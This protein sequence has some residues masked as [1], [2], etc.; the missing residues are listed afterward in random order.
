MGLINY[1]KNTM[2]FETRLRLKDTLRY[3]IAPAI[4]KIVGVAAFAILATLTYQKGLPGTDKP[5]KESELEIITGDYNG[6]SI[7][8]KFYV[9]DGDTIPVEIDGLPA[10]E[11]FNQ[12]M[13]KERNLEV[14][15]TQYAN[16]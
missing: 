11:Y 9:V 2:D 15:K 1:L 4:P 7:D 16:I 13:H 6:N 5:V 3:S 12:K 10:Q 8:D 14:Q